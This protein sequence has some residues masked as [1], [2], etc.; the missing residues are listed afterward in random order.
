MRRAFAAFLILTLAACSKQVPNP[1]PTVATAPADAPAA[2]KL[3][4]LRLSG[5]HT[6]GNL[7][8]YLVHDAKA[9]QGEVDF[10]TLEEALK[11]GARKVTEKADGAE[12]NELQ[13]ENAGD[14][15][16]YLQA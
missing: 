14:K 3:D 5:P 10:L 13:V 15:P 1:P 2:S 12:V 9:P 6:H 7:S 8:V 11:S 4:D 16:V